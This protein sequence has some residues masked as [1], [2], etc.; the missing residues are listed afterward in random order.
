[1]HARDRRVDRYYDPSTDQFIS[2][3][4]D[5][6]ETG[7]PYAYDRDDPLNEMDPLG[8]YSCG[9]RS[10]SSIV[11]QAKRGGSEYALTCG[12]ATTTRD[13]R[14]IGGYGVRHIQ[15]DGRHFGGNLS[16][17]GLDLIVDA[18]EHGDLDPSQS[19]ATKSTYLYETAAHISIDGDVMQE[20]PFT[21]KVVVNATFRTVTTAKITEP[22]IDQQPLNNC[23]VDGYTLC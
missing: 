17:A 20:I 23:N 16:N 21:V 13:G 15:D 10:A 6:A 5:V 9:K 8:L 7:Q 1:V 12:R 3:D 2:V 19:T 11:R 14:V 18:I 22:S 4:P